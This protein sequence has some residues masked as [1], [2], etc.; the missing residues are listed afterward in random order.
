MATERQVR[1]KPWLRSPPKAYVFSKANVID[2]V[3]G[4]ILNNVD[5]KVE[6]GKI[7]SISSAAPT[8]Y[9]SDFQTIDCQ[10]KYLCPGLIDSHVHLMAVPGYEDLSKAFG[11]PADVSLLRQPYVCAQML[12]RGFTTVRDCGGALFA[13]KEAIEDGVF[14]GPRLFIAG[15]AL[16]QAGGH[17]DYRGPHDH[18][19]CCGGATTG[20]GRLCNGVAECMA[21]V[22]EEVRMGSDFIKIMGSGGVSSPTDRIDQL[23]F[24]GEEIRAIVECADNA[25]V[26]VTAHAYTPRAIR[27]CV[28][29]GAR[30]IEHGNFIDRP[31]AELLA[32]KG[33]FLTPTL[34]TYAEMSDPKWE[35]YL[36][37]ESA[38]KNV[39]VLKAGLEALQI[40]SEAGVTLCYGSDLLGPL[41]AA[42][43]YEFA[44]RSKV[45]SPLAVLQSATINPAKMLRHETE[46]GQLKEGFA[47]DI[48]VLNKNPL[49]D[50][51]IF[52][53]PEENVLMIMKQ[54]RIYKSRW[55]NAVEDAAIPFQPAWLLLLKGGV[56]LGTRITR[57]HDY[58]RN[59]LLV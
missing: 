1:V 20:L 7:T 30:G 48:L 10:G 32:R 27:H 39:E 14:P 36:P 31:T 3:T 47:A 46:L 57:V 38:V 44:L 43:T 25:N 49:D 23:Q 12:H 54:G 15:H 11:N 9:S 24:T 18:S 28:E 52:D 16:S 2:V 37:Q 55:E 42:Q 17:A 40:A 51:T 5:V 26:Y 50:V 58:L 13:L 19:A 53:S 6:N 45:L 22:R 4:S 21:A 8:T 33:V 34:V 35:G 29:N 59:A 56:A 41:S